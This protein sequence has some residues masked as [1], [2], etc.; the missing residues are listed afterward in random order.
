M[1][2]EEVLARHERTLD[3]LRE[4]LD[5]IPDALWAWRPAPGSWSPAEV[6]DHVDRIAR[7]Y[8]Y[9]KL[10]ACLRGEGHPGGSRTL[11]GW[12]LLNAPWLAGIFRHRRDFPEALRPLP[13]SKPE[14]ARALD[15]LRH[16]ARRAAP[17]V[18]ADPGAS[19]VEH[20]ALGWL[21]A[22]QWFHFAEIH[23]RHHL[24]GQLARIHRAWAR[25]PGALPRTAPEPGR[26]VQARPGGA[27]EVQEKRPPPRGGR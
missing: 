26:P 24:E 14:A 19:R 22:P 9:P 21:T 6:Y 10:E 5:L 4:R 27:E 1:T 20:V 13:L 11:M 7:L 17:L 12:C 15:A 2:V 8:S 23:T 3:A 25:H 18:A 16:R